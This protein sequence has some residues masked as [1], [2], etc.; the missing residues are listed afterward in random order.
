MVLGL[1]GG[2]WGYTR[3]SAAGG[4]EPVDGPIIESKHFTPAELQRSSMDGLLNPADDPL[5]LSAES[6]VPL[7]I[8]G[9]PLWWVDTVVTD[10]GPFR[11]T[12]YVDVPVRSMLA[13]E[14]FDAGVCSSPR[15]R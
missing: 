10:D 15:S 1:A 5:P 11:Y 8:D 13:S 6:D 9:L 3:A 7:E 2:A 4:C 12:Y 14:F